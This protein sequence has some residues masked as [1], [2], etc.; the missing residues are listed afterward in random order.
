MKYSFT[1][2]RPRSVQFGAFCWSLALLMAL[3]TPAMASAA[4]APSAPQRSASPSPSSDGYT[5]TTEYWRQLER[6][7]SE[8]EST[9]VSLDNQAATAFPTSKFERVT[10]V[11][12]KLALKYPGAKYDGTSGT[13]P[14][15]NHLVATFAQD[16]KVSKI[17]DDYS[18]AGRRTSRNYFVHERI[19]ECSSGF[20]SIAGL[21]NSETPGNSMFT[22]VSYAAFQEAVGKIIPASQ[23]TKTAYS[24]TGVAVLNDAY[25]LF[26]KAQGLR[27]DIFA[28]NMLSS[29]DMYSAVLKHAQ[30]GY[31]ERHPAEIPVTD[32]PKAGAKESL[33][34]KSAGEASLWSIWSFFFG[35]LFAVLALIMALIYGVRWFLRRGQQ[36]PTLEER[37]QAG[38]AKSARNKSRSRR[39]GDFGKS[40]ELEIGKTQNRET[41]RGEGQHVVGETVFEV[42]GEHPASEGESTAVDRYAEHAVTQ[43][44]EK[45]VARVVDKVTD[46]LGENVALAVEKQVARLLEESIAVAV[47]RQMAGM[48][49]KSVT[50]AVEEALPPGAVEPSVALLESPA[51]VDVHQPVAESEPL[52]PDVTGGESEGADQPDTPESQDKDM[53]CAVCGNKMKVGT[54][55]KGSRAGKKF[56]VCSDYPSCRHFVPILSAS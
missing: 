13:V 55:T 33:S 30:T 3:L 32:S 50:R 42:V 15:P 5:L 31:K 27:M 45:A 41:S 10:Q 36:G 11:N 12:N 54:A 9:L 22:K 38:K 26:A 29:D 56:W 8:V 51:T 28:D 7:A 4:I 34:T 17:T 44:M 39:K 2:T 40:L 19:F 21:V 49:E 35:L 48:L 43:A 18:A 24:S 1:S 46:S 14:L 20:N 53:T 37:L 47:E 25:Q 6:L 16:L 23:S 52:S